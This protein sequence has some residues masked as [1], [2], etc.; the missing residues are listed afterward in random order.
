MT[1][2]ESSSEKGIWSPETDT[3]TLP[4]ASTFLQS[5]PESGYR[6]AESCMQGKVF[7][8]VAEIGAIYLPGIVLGG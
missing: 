1:S 8:K 5:W 7:A 6:Q 4:K 3:T 2:P